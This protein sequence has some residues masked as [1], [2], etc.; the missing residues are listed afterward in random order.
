MAMPTVVSGTINQIWIGNNLYDIEAKNPVPGV[1]NFKGT[2]KQELTD[3]G[4]QNAASSSGSPYV[5]NTGD[6]YL[7]S[8][9]A[10]ELKNTEF[11]WIK[12]SSEHGGHWEALGN[13]NAYVLKSTIPHTTG[14][15][16]STTTVTPAFTGTEKDISLSGSITVDAPVEA[17]PSGSTV[18]AVSLSGTY[19]PE[20]DVTVQSIT[21]DSGHKF[22]GS[23][24]VLSTI[25]VPKGTITISPTTIASGHSLSINTVTINEDDPALPGHD[26][27]V[28]FVEGDPLTIPTGVEIGSANTNSGHTLQMD[29]ITLVHTPT[30][31]TVQSEGSYT[32]QG[33]IKVGLTVTKASV[34][35]VTTP[36]TAQLLGTVTDSVLV[37][38]EMPNTQYVTNVSVL[39]ATASTCFTGTAK[40]ITVTSKKAVVTG[41]GPDHVFSPTGSVKGN[42]TLDTTIVED[43]I[44]NEFAE[45]EIQITGSVKGAH[46]FTGQNTDV[47]INYTPEGEVKGTHKFT[48][49]AKSVTISKALIAKVAASITASGKYKPEGTISSIELPSTT[50]THQLTLN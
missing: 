12:D 9:N 28:T 3:G 50:H 36:G 23:A 26:M 32:P 42:H 35:P 45:R 47:S 16:S 10:T 33:T 5:G 37:F 14:G 40:S 1:M 34:V 39:T 2:A 20:G 38:Y 13:E 6:V 8:P 18:P 46:L 7:Q 27:F 30:T 44:V 17:A 31:E 24:T 11:V 15:P 49:I 22:V 21:L 4:W 48:G 29:E 43:Y 41:V 19:T 25:I